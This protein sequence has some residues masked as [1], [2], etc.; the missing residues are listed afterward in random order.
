M[1]IIAKSKYVRQSPSKLRLVANSIRGLTIEKAEARLE[2]MPKRGAELILPVLRQAV[3]NAVNNF[4]L[5][6]ESL[7]IKKLEIN[8]GPRFKRWRFVGRGRVHPILKKT[9]HIIMTVEEASINKPAVKIIK[10]GR[11]NGT[12]S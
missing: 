4:G 3:A 9:S 6:K 10:K 7:F 12:Q 8:E 2:N 11:K 5:K 1:E